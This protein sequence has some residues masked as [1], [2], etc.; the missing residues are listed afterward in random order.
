MKVVLVSMPFGTVDTPSPALGLLAALLRREGIECRQRYFSLDFAARIG[1]ADYVG[2]GSYGLSGEWLFSGALFGD[3]A[4]AP[5]YFLRDL[6]DEG[7]A[8]EATVGRLRRLR[9]E[10]EPFIESCLASM[11]WGDYDLVG[12]TSTMFQQVAS[13]ALARRLSRAYPGLTIALGGANCEAEMGAE[14][15]RRFPFVDL[16]FSGESDETFPAAV[17]DL[18]HGKRPAPRPGLFVQGDDGVSASDRTVQ[19]VEDLDRL[20]YPEYDDYFA[21]LQRSPLSDQL[22]PVVPF[23]SARGCWW[24]QRHQCTFCGLNGCSL[25]FRRKSPDR[26]HDEI[27]HLSS[28]YGNRLAATD[29]ILDMDFFGTLLPRLAAGPDNVRLFYETK[30][31][32]DRQ[33]VDLLRAAGIRSIQPGIESLSDDVLQRMRKGCTALQNVQLLKWCYEYGVWPSWSF[34]VGI[35]GESKAEYDKMAGWVPLLAHLPPPVNVMPLR[36]DRFSPY[37]LDPASAGLCRVRPMTSYRRIYPFPEQSVARLAYFFEFEHEDG[38]DIWSYARTL[39]EA[40]SDHWRPGAQF[41]AL[42]ML[43]TGERLQIQDSRRVARR[44]FTELRGAEREIY[45]R[46]D[47]ARTAEALE[48]ETTDL[49]VD[50]EFNLRSFLGRLVDDGLMLRDGERYLSLAVTPRYPNVRPRGERTFSYLL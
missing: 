18:R 30:T 32:L 23:E 48:R 50:D 29:N 1:L 24:G 14:L 17:R 20:P 34:L 16:V 36:L 31:N 37:F 45:L 41:G 27:R 33:Q 10:A 38:R 5:E 43:D 35:P 9:D 6:R 40:V 25:A 15:I 11:A 3:E 47:R 44:P 21:E 4:P 26:V 42:R 19:P 46:C 7:G 28:R 39:L 13:L 49:P 2:F 12:F 22:D 8:S